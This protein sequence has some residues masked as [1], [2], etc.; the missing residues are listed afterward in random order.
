MSYCR[1]LRPRAVAASILGSVLATASLAGAL[2]GCGVDDVAIGGPATLVRVEPTA[3]GPSCAQG[4]VAIHTGLD[5]DND[6]FLDDDE[7]TSTQYSCN[8]DA[9][10]ACQGGQVLTG[11]VAVRSASEW[12]QLRGVHCVQ[13]DLFIAGVASG[14]IPTLLE[15]GIVTGDVV[16]A[17]N[18][19]FTSLRG[20]GSLHTVGGTY[21]VQGND[22]LVSL[23][24]L[25]RLR[26]AESLAIVADNQLV[27][28]TGLDSLGDFGGTLRISNNAALQKLT[29][30][31]QLTRCGRGLQLRA[32]PQLRDLGALGQLREAGSL[33]LAS[34]DAL[35]SVTL[36]ALQTVSVRVLITGNSALTEVSL[37]ALTATGDFI[38]LDGNA[39]L[40][41]FRAPQLLT[42]GGLLAGN[43]TAI[44][45]LA[46]PG[47]V[48]VTGVVDL[49]GLPLLAQLS[50]D[51]L[52]S[53]GADLLLSSLS[54][55]GSLSGLP[56]LRTIGGNF[57]ASSNAALTSFAGLP[58]LSLIAGDF[59][60]DGNAGLT[61]L[62]GLTALRD[63]GGKLIITNNAQ[64]PTATAAAFAGRLRVGGTVTITGNR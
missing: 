40:T 32:N 35:A 55:L 39:A 2:G 48:Y 52:T 57:T 50:L 64:L 54:Q 62:G 61:S 43:D 13:G 51:N 25:E 34:N 15:L 59:T 6:T 45:S 33:E 7:I 21:L 27:D 53:I 19:S 17:A 11:A 41:S 3:P 63:V 47:L 58:S 44:R 26:S 42:A 14:E 49:R 56:R 10:V 46:L 18:P 38:R 24:G 31:E 23:H 5:R 29:G 60:V 22:G 4:G 30:L 37:P 8:G 12:D 9:A 20:L 28:L 36:P 16:V 1:P